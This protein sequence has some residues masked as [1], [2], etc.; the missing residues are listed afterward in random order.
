LSGLLTSTNVGGTNSTVVQSANGCPVSA[1]Y[2]NGQ[3]CVACSLPQYW[4]LAIN[5][6]VYCPIGQNFYPTTNQCLACPA[7]TTFNS[8]TYFCQWTSNKG[9]RFMYDCLC[10]PY[11][12]ML[13]YLIYLN[14]YPN[15]IWY[16]RYIEI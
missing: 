2:W 9:E 11:F 12:T 13:L 14:Y 5:Q 8:T 16:W 15:F 1:P 7:G 3:A 6:C 10:V 4:N